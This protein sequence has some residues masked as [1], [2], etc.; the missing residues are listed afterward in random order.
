MVLCS[1]PSRACDF[2]LPF[3]GV[4]KRTSNAVHLLLGTCSGCFC[5][6][7]HFGRGHLRVDSASSGWSSTNSSNVFR[8]IY[9]DDSQS[10]I[11][12]HFSGSRRWNKPVRQEI[13][14]AITW[15]GRFRLATNPRTKREKCTRHFSPCPRVHGRVQTALLLTSGRRCFPFGQLVERQCLWLGSSSALFAGL[16]RVALD[17][18]CAGSRSSAPSYREGGRDTDPNQQLVSWQATWS[19]EESHDL[20]H[21]RTPAWL[22]SIDPLA[23]YGGSSSD[24]WWDLGPE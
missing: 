13:P 4:S 12:G 8:N 3:S 22:H 16:G 9:P 14:P 1:P 5:L 17:A 7:Y 24:E 21:W 23:G 11:S 15:G 2:D 18:L 19:R 10:L 6:F 20:W